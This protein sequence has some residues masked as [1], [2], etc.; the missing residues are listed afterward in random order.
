MYTIIEP[1]IRDKSFMLY[2]KEGVKGISRHLA[3]NGF[4]F[5]ADE[6][7]LGK[8]AQAIGVNNILRHI[9]L[10]T[11]KVFKTIVVC[12]KTVCENVWIEQFKLWTN[13]RLKVCVLKTGKDIQKIDSQDLDVLIVPYSLINKTDIVKFIKQNNF[14]FIIADEA[15]YL[16]NH[17]SG[18]GKAVFNIRKSIMYCLVLT[19]SP[20]MNRPI[21]L[22][23]ILKNTGGLFMV[24]PYNHKFD[25]GK[26]YCNGKRDY[27]GHWDF[28]GSSRELEL[29]GKL[30][31][32]I[33]RVKS[34]VLGELPEVTYC[35]IPLDSNKE[36]DRISKT[37]E[38]LGYIKT[39]KLK[40]SG[41]IGELAKLRGE[42]ALSKISESVDFIENLLEQKSKIVIFGYHRKVIAE[43]QAKLVTYCPVVI[44]GET[45]SSQRQENIEKF[46]NDETVRLFIGQINAAGVGI[47]GLQ[48]V[49]DT[50]IFIE[51]TWVPEDINQAISRC[52][53]MG[54]SSNVTA[55]FLTVKNS[56]DEYILNTIIEKQQ[57]INKIIA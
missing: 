50:V 36:T 34:E 42:L 44:T 13:C 24:K 41:D 2:Q 43:L 6:P 37:L 28:S 40:I 12:P 14:N 10:K 31:N 39:D 30:T 27:F 33:R 51:S 7:G 15:H 29:K 1:K 55:Y 17:D 35:M 38:G 16:K 19:G 49:C 45:S 9:Y 21:E 54:Q 56:L 22:H 46:K 3:V 4:S 52:H 25:F 48:E 57:V 5:L 20:I 18:R 53:R 47:N 11:D 8:T 23:G 32:F 26:R